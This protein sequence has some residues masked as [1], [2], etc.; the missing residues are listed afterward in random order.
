MRV[1][2]RS[3]NPGLDFRM[4]SGSK[5]GSAVEVD[6]ASE[7]S[8]I[9]ESVQEILEVAAFK[10]KSSKGCQLFTSKLFENIENHAVLAQSVER[11]A[12]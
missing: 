5:S 12:L 11:K 3:F 10:W 6:E 9:S 8:A 1:R 4:V 7:I 2:L